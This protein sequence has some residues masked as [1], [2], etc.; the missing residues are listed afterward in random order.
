MSQVHAP[1]G[2]SP[3][4]YGR[5][6]SRSPE[7]H[8]ERVRSAS[9]GSRRWASRARGPGRAPAACH[10]REPARATGRAAGATHDI[11]ARLWQHGPRVCPWARQHLLSPDTQH[12]SQ[13]PAALPTPNPVHSPH[14]GWAVLP[15][16]V[17]PHPCLQSP[18]ALLQAASAPRH[19]LKTA[20]TS[21]APLSTSVHALPRPAWLLR[22]GAPHTFQTFFQKP[23]LSTLPQ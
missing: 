9:S 18:P 3:H 16:P 2:L 12:L 6:N 21:H 10:V 23:S 13:L 8:Q 17:G 5:H 19:S 14:G 20:G 1:P 15:Q 4:A 22:T 7:P 11:L